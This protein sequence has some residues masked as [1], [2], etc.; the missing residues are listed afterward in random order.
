MKKTFTLIETIVA[1]SILTIGILGIS[2]L[3]SSQIS[4]THFSKNKLIAAYL[5]QEGIEIVRNIRDTNWLNGRNWDEFINIDNATT[6]LLDY[7]SEKVPDPNFTLCDSLKFDGDFYNC[8]SG[9]D[10]LFKRETFILKSGDQMIVKVT[11]SW[12]ERG[13]THRY[14]LVGKLYKWRQ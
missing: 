9:S 13:K 11:I 1:I 10:T 3:I 14:Q 4:S 8:S 5:A 2:F 7:T 12:K 6:T